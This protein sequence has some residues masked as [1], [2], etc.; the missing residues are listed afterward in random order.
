LAQKYAAE[1]TSEQAGSSSEPQTQMH[2]ISHFYAYSP[3]VSS[4]CGANHYDNNILEANNVHNEVMHVESTSDQIDGNET[5]LM[6]SNVFQDNVIE[7]LI[8]QEQTTAMNSTLVSSTSA[9]NM[10]RQDIIF[11][12]TSEAVDSTTNSGHQL[13]FVPN[14]STYHQSLDKMALQS[15]VSMQSS[16][17]HHLLQPLP[18]QSPH[19]LHQ[20]PDNNILHQQSAEQ[21]V[22]EIQE[23]AQLSDRIEQEIAQQEHVI[24]DL[25]VL[26]RARASLPAEYLYIQ[27][28][29]TSATVFG[30]FAKKTIPKRTQ[31]GPVEGVIV[32]HN[33][34]NVQNHKHNLMIFITES[35]IL[36]QSDENQSN[37][38]KFVRSANTYEEQN[39]A[40][41]SKEQVSINNINEIELK[42]YFL[43]TRPIYAREELKVWYSK[44]YGEKF[45][46]KLLE[47]RPTLMPENDEKSIA[48]NLRKRNTTTAI[49][50]VT[51]GGHKLRNKIAKTQQQQLQ[52]QEI[53]QNINTGNDNNNNENIGT[54]QSTEEVKENSTQA[55]YQCET[56]QKVFP[57]FYSL[58]RHQIM[59]SG[60]DLMLQW[61]QNSIINNKF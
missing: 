3:L 4:S 20:N 24:N 30:V 15:M 48:N 14:I 31:F 5:P 18:P 47:P 23:S 12:C 27:E 28:P 52:K 45:N 35:L 39:L 21:C 53:E 13:S 34:S 29:D 49:D 40:L 41:V 19:Y 57:R 33:S 26:S 11:E 32:Q 44:E 36:D 7:N 38:M 56:C 8:K 43:T 58:R 51:T 37:W 16:D 1:S 54:V 17:A 61:F 50:I 59:H 22:Q 6:Q 2:H 25:P 9:A 60:I 42:F 10:C 55:K 46:L